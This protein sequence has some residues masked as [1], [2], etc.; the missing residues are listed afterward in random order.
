M[1]VCVS[2]TDEKRV[3]SPSGLKKQSITLSPPAAGRF[4]GRHSSPKIS[5]ISA[6][7]V[8]RSASG[9]SILLTMIIRQRS[10]SAACCIM[11]MAV[12]STPDSAL[13]TT[14]AVSTACNTLKARPKKSFNPGVSR[15]LTCFPPF[16]NQASEELSEC[17]YCCSLGSKSQT[18][19]PRSML[20]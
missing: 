14:A 13:M 19:S 17:R 4:R 11:V 15:M 20:P 6:T 12:G 10:S 9:E 18:V 2:A 1:V 8:S 5:R 7:R 3:S 16:S